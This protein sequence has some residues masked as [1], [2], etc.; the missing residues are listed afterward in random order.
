MPAACAASSSPLSAQG[1]P[2]AA[3]AGFAGAEGL[4]ALAAAFGLPGSIGPWRPLGPDLLAAEHGGRTLLA[5]RHRML[6]PERAPLLEAVLGAA[7]AAGVA[8]VMLPARG[9]AL[10]LAGADGWYG[11][12]EQA[13][14][15]VPEAGQ[16]LGRAAR[17]VARLHLALARVPGRA[18]CPRAVAP[19]AAAGLLARAGLDELAR[20]VAPVA[21][22]AQALP[23]QLVHRDLHQG[24]FLLGPQGALVLD[25]DSFASGP[26]VADAL[27][28]ALRLSGG[29]AAGMG[30]FMAVYGALA[31]PAPVEDAA[32][33]AAL[34]WDVLAKLA[35]VLREREAG[36][37]YYEKDFQKY[38]GLA[39][40]AL[41]LERAFPGGVRALGG[42]R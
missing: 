10:V 17:A 18:A 30:R 34:A 29:D 40:R 6:T 33:L 20:A 12:M 35:F 1:G 25:Y 3:G 31:P 9:G 26:R 39:R 22:A 19:Q 13:P 11:L 38:I 24:N 27:F 36:N 14:G 42:G 21:A 16:G 28:A 32:G 8:P 41:E 7:R 2:C 4:A 5:K 37:G 15:E 23:G